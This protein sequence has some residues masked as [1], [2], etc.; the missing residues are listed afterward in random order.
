MTK[1]LPIGHFMKTSAVINFLE[2][3]SKLNLALEVKKTCKIYEGEFDIYFNVDDL[4]KILEKD[5]FQEMEC[6]CVTH[7]ILERDIEYYVDSNR[8]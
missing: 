3:I 2:R 6:E 5:L 7:M 8:E 1:K 4:K